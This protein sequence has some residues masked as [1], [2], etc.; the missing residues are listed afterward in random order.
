MSI[1][2]DVEDSLAPD[3]SLASS[4]SPD[5]TAANWAAVASECLGKYL[6]GSSVVFGPSTCA[7]KARV[8]SQW[9]VRKKRYTES[10]QASSYCSAECC[11]GGG[12]FTYL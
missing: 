11:T 6:S 3:A 8:G 4:G 5:R 1:G 2:A 10:N 7:L 12:S 9:Q